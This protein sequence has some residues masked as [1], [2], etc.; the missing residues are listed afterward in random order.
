M[1]PIGP[2]RALLLAPSA[3]L[4]GGV[5]TWLDQTAASLSREGWRVVVGLVRGVRFHDPEAYAAAHPGLEVVEVPCFTGTWEGRARAVSEALRRVRP[6]VLAVINVGDALEGARRW[7]ASAEGRGGRV[8]FT[9]HGFGPAQLAEIERYA[10]TIDRVVT[11]NGLTQGLVR[12]I[13]GIHPDRVGYAPYGAEAPVKEGKTAVASGPLRLAWVGR[14][15]QSQKRAEDLGRILNLCA[16]RGLDFRCDVAGD[17]PGMPALRERLAPLVAD[18]RVRLRGLLSREQLYEE[19]YPGLDVLLLTSSWETGPIVAWEAMRHGAV[20]VSALYRGLVE[21]G[22]L[23]H[24][25]NCLLAPV[26]DV[27][28][29]AEAVASLASDPDRRRRLGEAG[30]ATAESRYTVET[31]GRAWDRELRAA[32]EAPAIEPQPAPGRIPSGRLDALLGA[33]LA[34]SLRRWTGRRHAPAED[35]DE[36]P[37]ASGGAGT[38][39]FRAA[40]QERGL[41]FDASGEVVS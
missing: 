41:L 36:W 6:D 28:A 12:E 9:I 13:C 21:E 8:A 34:E 39:R 11:T 37:H 38:G 1:K 15:E 3:S 35:S 14:V 16:E 18:G 17:G 22:A 40:L 27:A 23:V 31:S 25:E 29:L 26:G 2:G 33:S 7:K 5:Q 24:G 19:V 10:G 30:R 20:V 4:W 32:M